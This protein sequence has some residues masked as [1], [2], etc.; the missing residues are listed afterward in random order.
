MLLLKNERRERGEAATSED[1]G[2]FQ[3]FIQKW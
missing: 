2:E 3:V 1:P